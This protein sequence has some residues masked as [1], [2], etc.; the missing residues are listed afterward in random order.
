MASINIIKPKYGTITVTDSSLLYMDYFYRIT[1][2]R[3]FL[4]GTSL[5]DGTLTIMQGAATETFTTRTN[6]TEGYE[7]VP[8]GGE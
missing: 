4:H 8:H 3:A 6:W 1:D 2:V 5:G 7:T